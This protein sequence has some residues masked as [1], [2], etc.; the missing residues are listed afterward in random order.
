MAGS[1]ALAVRPFS[2]WDVVTTHSSAAK[3]LLRGKE[4]RGC[5]SSSRGQVRVRKKAGPSAPLVPTAPSRINF[6]SWDR[7]QHHLNH[8]AKG[9]E[10]KERKLNTSIQ[11]R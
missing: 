4:Q 7:K 8:V 3:E 9:L 10:E 1:P 11:Q 6:L 2:S 5:V